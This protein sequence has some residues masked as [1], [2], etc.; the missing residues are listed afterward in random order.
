MISI[1]RPN[2]IIQALYNVRTQH[3]YGFSQLT[4]SF[5]IRAVGTLN[6]FMK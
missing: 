4:T 6:E 2:S 3:I 5:S 1:L